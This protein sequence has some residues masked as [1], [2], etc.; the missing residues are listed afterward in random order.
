MSLARTQ[1]GAFIAGTWHVGS[2]SEQVAVLNPATGAEIANVSVCGTDVVDAAVLA[3]SEAFAEWRW[4]SPTERGRLLRIVGEVIRGHAEELAELESRENGKPVRDALRFDVTYAHTTFDYF[5]GLADALSGDIVD[6]G[7]IEAHVVREPYGVVGAI[8]PFNWPPIHF[9]A[10][11]A[12]ALASG[13]TVVIKP[14]EQAPLTVLRM[15]EL[16]NRVLPPGLLNAVTGVD[17]GVAL[18]AHPGLGRLTFTGSSETGRKVMVSA[19]QTLTVPTL[20]LGGKNA[21][22]VFPDADLDLTLHAA[23]E[24]A[25]F[26]QGEACTATARLIVHDDVYDEFVERFAAATQQLV[27]GE[28]TDPATD[29]GPMVD[30]RQQESVQSEI[31]IARQEGART[32]AEASTPIDDRLAGGFWVAPTVFADVTPQMR[33]AHEEVF[34]PVVGFM[35]FATEA[36]ALEI[37]N[38]TAYGLTAALFTTDLERARRMAP[39]LDVGMVFVNNYFRASLLGTPFGGVKDSGFGREGAAETLH[40]FTRSKNIRYPSVLRPVPQWDSARQVL[41]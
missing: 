2:A 26:N 38:G 3:A 25:F 18:A 40:E 28:G 17:A 9:A 15:V 22:I 39:R 24:G 14:G 30:A 5:A 37:A 23:I 31:E 1:F 41:S 4:R 29:I 34:G 13:N 8:L 7:S 33:L 19:A 12:P 35:R 20:E 32:V 16:A 11:C 21:L 36:E 10:K 6:Q 27:V